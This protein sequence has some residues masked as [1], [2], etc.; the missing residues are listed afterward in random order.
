MQL[1][2]GPSLLLEAYIKKMGKRAFFFICSYLLASTSL[3]TYSS[4]F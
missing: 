2:P 1:R 4:V 3:G